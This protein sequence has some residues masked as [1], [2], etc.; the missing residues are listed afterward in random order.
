MSTVVDTPEYSRA[1]I[2]AI[3]DRKNAITECVRAVDPVAALNADA[4]VDPD[5]FWAALALAATRR[6]LFDG[7]AHVRLLHDPRPVRVDA[8]ACVMAV[9]AATLLELG[10]RVERSIA[11]RSHDDVFVVWAH[12]CTSDDTWEIL[13]TARSQLRSPR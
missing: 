4:E 6:D 8:L 13:R 5:L 1:E 12:A 2:Q 11:E 10:A 9:D 7:L 3:C